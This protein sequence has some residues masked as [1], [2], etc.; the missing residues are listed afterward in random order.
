MPWKFTCLL[1]A[2]VVVL[3]ALAPPSTAA[4]APTFNRDI[5]PI[6]FSKCAG[7]HH[8]GGIAPFALTG[9]RDAKKHA[10]TIAQVT[11]VPAMP[12]WPP[13]PGHSEFI[14]ARRLTDGQIATIAQWV[15]TGMKEGAERDL[16]P[17][18]TFRNDW[19]LG[20]PDIIVTPPKAFP[21]P[22]DGPDIYR[23]LV[24]AYE[25]TANRFVRAV[26]FQPGNSAAVHHAFVLVDESGDARRLETLETLPGFPGMLAGRGARSPGGFVSWQPG[27]DP[28]EVPEGMAWPLKK[29]SDLV[30][31]L[32]LRS[33]GKPEQVQPRI[34]LYFTDQPLTRPNIVLL[35]R[36]ATIDI[37]AGEASHPVEASYQLPTTNY[38]LASDVTLIGLS[39]HLHYLGKEARGWAELPDGTRQEL[40]HI[41][42]WDFNWQ[43]HYRYVKPVALPRGTT[44]RMRFTYDNSTHNPANP[45]HPPKRV[46]YGLQSVDEM[47]E[48]WFWVETRTPSE[49]QTLR[50]D[51]FGTWGLADK[52]AINEA[53]LKRDPKDAGSRTELAVALYALGKIDEALAHL[54]QAIADDPKTQRAYYALGTLFVKRG[55]LVDAVTAFT[56]AIE[57][58][59]NDA[60]A[61]NNLGAVL[62][63]LGKAA[64]AIPHFESALRLDPDDSLARESLAKARAAV[65]DAAK[66]QRPASSLRL[67]IHPDVNV[68]GAAEIPNHVWTFQLPDIPDAIVADVLILVECHVQ[69]L[70]ARGFDILDGFV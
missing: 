36:P 15:K 63:S 34:G 54:R 59:P 48:L 41:K 28:V 30:L 38:Q 20:P 57:I 53:L 60:K 35:L 23:N 56:H 49:L 10:K 13:E 70:D 47:G 66:R 58:D 55:E 17:P 24:M 19:K 69:V 3:T 67:H 64:E 9:F 51:Y 52:V 33:T 11:A 8:D 16:P 6:F 46:Q 12:P 7:C 31:Q 61:C 39:P 14:G 25:A 1:P 40:I 22:A 68:R 27:H 2:V 62:L 37:P 43:G 65:G 50:R 18:P 5:A 45:N 44:L 32:H 4:E 29:R 21:L 42:Q 26:E